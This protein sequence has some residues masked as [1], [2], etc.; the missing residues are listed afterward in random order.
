M[1]VHMTLQQVASNKGPRAVWV[2][3]AKNLFGVVVK[4]MSISGMLLVEHI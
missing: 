1:P 3:A 4:L 2:L